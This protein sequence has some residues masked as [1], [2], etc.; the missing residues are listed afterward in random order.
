[1]MKGV[2]H[3]VREKLSGQMQKRKARE[4]GYDGRMLLEI[5]KDKEGI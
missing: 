2:A 3:T 5:G 1:M 4:I